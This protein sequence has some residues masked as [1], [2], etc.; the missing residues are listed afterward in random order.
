MLYSF[1]YQDLFLNNV[2]SKGSYICMTKKE[3]TID[4]IIVT[5]AVLGALIIIVGLFFQSNSTQDT[6]MHLSAIQNVAQK[7][8]D[9]KD[10]EIDDDTLYFTLSSR[11]DKQEFENDMY[12][13]LKKKNLEHLFYLDIIYA[14]DIKTE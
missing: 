3:S 4:L 1:Y 13:L 10:T 5:C 6:D 9:V 11:E 2:N 8:Y 7:N 12:K 14:D